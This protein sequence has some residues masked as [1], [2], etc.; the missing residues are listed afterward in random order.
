MFRY[1]LFLMRPLRWLRRTDTP[2]IFAEPTI[3]IY[4]MRLLCTML[5]FVTVACDLGPQGAVTEEAKDWNK[6]V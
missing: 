6:R 1:K 3:T 2:P 5:C 4:S